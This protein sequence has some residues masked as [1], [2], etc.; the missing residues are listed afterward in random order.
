MNT[1]NPYFDDRI[2]D[3]LEDDP[4]VAPAQVLDTVLAAVPSISQRRGPAAWLR[5]APFR[6]APFPLVRL[7]MVVA[8]LVLAALLGMAI[9][10]D[11]KANPSPTAAG[12][13]TFTS[14]V[15]GYT[16]TYP[17]TWSVVPGKRPISA[18]VLP[19]ALCEEPDNIWI[20][21]D[22]TAITI[23]GSQLPSGMTL[24]DWTASVN[25]RIP[26]RFVV[27]S[28]CLAGQEAVTV[29]GEP[30]TLS[31][32]DCP[33]QVVLWIT[34]VHAGAGWN[35]VWTDVPHLDLATIR[36]AFDRFLA[37]FRFGQQPLAT[38]PIAPTATPSPVT[39]PLPA[40]I[41]GAWYHP[42]PAFMTFYR[43]GD[44]YCVDV[45]HTDLDCMLWHPVGQEKETGI[46]TLEGNV[47]A[48]A[49][50]SGYCTG[51]TS[52]YNM[53]LSGDALS[54][55]ELPVGCQGGSYILTRA[56]TGGTPTAPPE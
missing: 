46:V 23:A 28:G 52:H 48:L 26:T 49:M 55:T 13:A 16:V 10:G 35:L 21:P 33:T 36:P 50:K 2:A 34:V 53:T 29:D 56:G 37:S 47:I 38:I 20:A 19:C 9:S 3:W 6:V 30:G 5:R 27:F 43:A 4:T 54:L 39:D 51:F 14:P 7:A 41:F 22:L 25:D 42:A 32:Y 8:S 24:A 11:P 17:A 15:Y 40:G 18:D 12:Q 1:T 44:P 31:T 45:L